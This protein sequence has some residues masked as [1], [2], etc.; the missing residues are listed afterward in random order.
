MPEKKLPS[1]NASSLGGTRL[2][3][4]DYT[5]ISGLCALCIPEKCLFLCEVSK[6]ALRGRETLYPEVEEFGYSTAAANK[7]YGLDWSDIQL[8][9][10]LSEFYGVESDE[11]LFED[12]SVEARFAGIRL[13]LPVFIAAL[14]ST[15]IARKH[16][17]GLAA[18]AAISGTMIVVGENVCGMDSKAVF[19]QGVV[20]ESPELERRVRA[21][22]DY[23][24]G[25]YGDIAVQTNV[26][27]EMMGVDFYALSKLEVG[28][29]EKKFGQGAKSIGGE[30]RI[31]SIER[32]LELKKRGYIVI[33]DPEDEAVREAYRRGLIKSF[34]R[35]SRV[36][37]PD[38][39]SFLER[40]DRLR[41]AGAKRVL[42]KTGS[43]RPAAVA[44]V[45]KLASTARIDGVTFDGAGGGTG[46]SP[47]SMMNESGVPTIYLEVWAVRAAEILSK[48]GAHVPDIAMAGGFSSE[49]HVV[50]AIALSG[51]NG[52][53]YVKAV[54]MARAP[55]L[56]VA[57][58]KLLL[59]LAREGKLPP[60][61]ARRWGSEPARLFTSYDELS[62]EYGRRVGDLVESGAIGLYTYF[63]KIAIGIKILLA[64]QRKASLYLLNRRDL[65]ALTERASRVTGLPLVSEVDEDLFNAILSA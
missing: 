6:A 19:S 41:E 39:D 62:R 61:L 29:I 11:F 38:V 17:E 32:A 49:H 45:M 9:P 7:D 37:K 58:S 36:K 55:I 1:D 10:N 33:P 25:V 57:K 59:S 63:K 3:V 20:R 42:I 64:G 15:D 53:P 8:L 27:D 16:W 34:E 51:V 31:S 13:K 35:H 26:E 46:M 18:G 65:A 22:R 14:G 52:E 48:R 56:A 43:Y 47:V 60:E 40:V 4:Q 12:V 2:R 30:V 5:P 24:D 44:F 54:A 21:F 28:I 23:W 50:K